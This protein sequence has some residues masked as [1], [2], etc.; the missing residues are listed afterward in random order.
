MLTGTW[1]VKVHSKE[2]KL[3]VGKSGEG[4]LWRE[5]NQL[6]KMDSLSHLHKKYTG[7]L[8]TT[9]YTFFCVRDPLQ[10]ELTVEIVN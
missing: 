10:T 7:R 8:S 1:E 3:L 6:V 4:S 5:K 2:F 9:H